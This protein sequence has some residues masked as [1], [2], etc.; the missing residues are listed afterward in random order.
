MIARQPLRP[1]AAAQAPE[2]G[3]HG[4]HDDAL[5]NNSYLVEVGQHEAVVIDPPRDPG[6]QI[7]LAEQIGVRIAA[8]LETHVHADYVSGA[9]EHAACGADVFVPKDAAVAWLHQNVADG[10]RVRFGDVAF[11]ALATPG[12]TPEH[13]AYVLEHA[14][15]PR[16]VFTGGSLI[17]GGAGRTDLLG[18]ARTD[19]LAR[20]Q[21]RSLRLLRQLPDAVR[22]YP[23][24]GA[25]SFCLA[26]T[27]SVENPTIGSERITNPLLAIHDEDTFGDE[28]RRGFG[29][30][31]RYYCHLQAVN[32]AGTRLLRDLSPPP[33]LDPRRVVRRTEEGAVLVDARP[34]HEWAVGHPAGA[35]S[36]ALRPAFP[37][38]LGWVVPFGT[39]VILIADGAERA[40]AVRLARAIGYDDLAVLDGDVD[41]W[42][43][44]GL[45]TSTTEE[46]TPHEAAERQRAGAVLLDVRQDVE[47]DVLRIPGALH[48]ELG[49]IIAGETPDAPAVIAFCGHGE[50]SATAAGL[51]E[52]R[53]VRVANLIGGTAAWV[54]AGLPVES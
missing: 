13:L 14:G 38:W 49:A 19:E 20:A 17:V 43:S 35:I 21:F 4:I 50:R 25:G 3:V 32:R 24:H 46:L 51:L 18:D 42:R 34:I 22:V 12:H 52:Q 5:A 23:T 2:P 16:A 7:R 1:A 26:S 33:A 44:E 8:T 54:D 36:N 53:G 37:S 39:S 45:P 29:T 28:L 9:R 30:F 6:P 41:A 40:E 15:E 47:F 27:T 31:P 11:R 48:L 10:D